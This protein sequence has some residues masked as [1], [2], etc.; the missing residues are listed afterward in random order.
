MTEPY[1]NVNPG[2]T[3]TWIPESQ[4]VS[5]LYNLPSVAPHAQRDV[6]ICVFFGFIWGFF[7]ALQFMKWGWFKK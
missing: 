5:Y 3:P 4:A 6:W 1:I 2:L 7:I